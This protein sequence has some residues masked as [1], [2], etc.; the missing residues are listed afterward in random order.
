MKRICQPILHPVFDPD[1]VSH[2]LSS[3]VIDETTSV[4][5]LLSAHLLKYRT[6][7]SYARGKGLQ[8]FRC[9]DE[10]TEEPSEVYT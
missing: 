6:K 2:L 7:D 10:G 8:R 5:L 3:L 9:T 4:T 1:L